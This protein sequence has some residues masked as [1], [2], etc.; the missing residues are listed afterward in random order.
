MHA[1]KGDAVMAKATSRGKKP[2]VI[3]LAAILTLAGAGVAFA[4]WTSTGTGSGT[5]TTGESTAFTIESETAVGTIAPGSAGQTVDFTVTNPA[6]SAQ[7]LTGVT[8]ALATA[9]GTPWAP[10]GGCLVADYTA[11]I[12]T[13]PAAGNI[14]VGGSVDG[15][16]TVTLAN[17]TAN[18]DACQG[19]EVPLYFVAS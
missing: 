1:N 13:A 10:T 2:V 4:Y 3:A 15:T 16:A 17:T 11:S 5:A 12:T 9:D 19:Q 8:V 14:P 18:Q 6:D 7:F